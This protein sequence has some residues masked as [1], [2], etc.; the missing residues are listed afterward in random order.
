M[1]RKQF[2]M[3][4]AAIQGRWFDHLGVDGKP[5]GLR[6]K[7]ASLDSEAY[8]DALQ[9]PLIR[10]AQE[11]MEGGQR[12][13]ILPSPAVQRQNQIAALAKHI[14]LSW[15][16]LEEEDGQPTPNTLENRIALLGEQPFRQAVVRFAS[17]AAAFE[18]QELGNSGSTAE[19][20][21][22]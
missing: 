1:K 20:S 17:N 16:G 11:A 10:K 8:Q 13:R 4:R 5:S 19:S 3:P 14:L 9:E 2:K 6:L 12:G 21:L 18:E 7:V 15:D 22:D